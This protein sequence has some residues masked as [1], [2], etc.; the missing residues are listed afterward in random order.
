M[1]AIQAGLSSAV[2]ANENFRGSIAVH[3][4]DT[5]LRKALERVACDGLIC[6]FGVYKG[7]TLRIIADT[8]NGGLVYGFDSFQGLPE[9]WR[10]GF[11]K[12]AFNVADKELP[13][14]ANN[15][16]LYPGLFNITLPAMLKDDPRHAAFLHIDCDLYSSTKVIFESLAN[17]LRAGTVIVFDEYF[18][19]P[20]WKND[21]HRALIEAAHDFSFT[22]DYILYNP[23]GQQVAVVVT[24]VCG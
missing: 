5:L 2:F 17:R 19:F 7:H 12:G 13:S 24:G 1:Q 10:A 18:N 22:Y 21:E 8:V 14:F 20:G 23:R 6:E 3:D 15:V 11:D 9:A 16:K 4:R